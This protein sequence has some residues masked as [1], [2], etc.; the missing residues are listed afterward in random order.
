MHL[1]HTTA[2][3]EVVSDVGRPFFNGTSKRREIFSLL[4][5]GSC[6]EVHHQNT[7]S[8]YIGVGWLKLRW[9]KV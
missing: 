8:E 7:E 1:L 5:R 6:M 4:F 3:Q 2:G 9:F